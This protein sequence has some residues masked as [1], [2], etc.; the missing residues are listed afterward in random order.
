MLPFLAEVM[1]QGTKSLRSGPLRGGGVI[2][3]GG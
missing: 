2:R 3:E 1:R